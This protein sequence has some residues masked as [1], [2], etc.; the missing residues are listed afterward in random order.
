[1]DLYLLA[2]PFTDEQRAV[3]EADAPILKVN[4]VAGSGKTTTLLEFAAHR[5]KSRILYLAYNRSVAED[6]RAKAQVRS[7]GNLT[8]NT[9]HGLAYRQVNG[10]RYELEG[11]LS[12]WRLLDH[13]VPDSDRGTEQA[14]LYAWLLKDLVNYYLNSTVTCLDADLLAFYAA[15]TAPGEH[16][17]ELLNKRGDEILGLV[18]GILSDMKHRRAPAVHDFYLKLFQ[19]A[20]VRLPYDIIL[21]DEAQD[22]SG[23]MLSIIGR[24][25]H[26]QRVFVGDSFQQIYAFRYAVNSLDR[27]EGQ[28]YRLSRTFRF[29]DGLA[30]YLSQRINEAYELLGEPAALEIRGTDADTRFGKRAYQGRN[31]LAVIARSN[32]SLF[33]AVLERLFHGAR[34]L[35]FEGG[36]SGYA[37]MNARVVGLLYLKQG[38]PGKIKDPFLRKFGSFEDARRFAKDTQNAG[39]AIM[40]DLVTRYGAKLFD[41][42]R[43]IRERLVDKKQAQFIFTTTHKA[44]GQEYDCVEMVE[45]DFATRS[46][47][48]KLLNSEPDEVIPARV[49]EEIN[50]Y[51]VAATRARKSIRL[52]PF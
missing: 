41:F 6:V 23:V 43:S 18:R 28:A 7:L 16:L 44:K 11:E 48:A 31:P 25:S 38:Q 1:L 22:T 9:L 37:F 14:V 26:A 36:Y 46:D 15:A 51:Y 24:Q 50:V 49:K 5:P 29:G 42:D 47:L 52:A 10:Q 27:V 40:I 33:E 20:R 12:E 4:A 3:I 13:Y 30:R 2:M 45:D 19:F 32:L 8:I 39:L 21:V 17:R 34:A 35:H